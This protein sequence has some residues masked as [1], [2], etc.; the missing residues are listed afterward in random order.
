MHNRDIAPLKY[1]DAFPSRSDRAKLLI[2]YKQHAFCI[3]KLAALD[4][5]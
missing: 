2:D 5:Q 4:H 1:D 3:N